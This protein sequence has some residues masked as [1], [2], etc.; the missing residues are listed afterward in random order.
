MGASLCEPRIL[1]PLWGWVRY[2]TGG[3]V[4]VWGFRNLVLIAD[5]MGVV[6]AGVEYSVASGAG[7][8]ML[9]GGW[10]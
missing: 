1:G 8:Q 4:V 2:L 7:L 5:L 3:G 9:R 10:G 6:V